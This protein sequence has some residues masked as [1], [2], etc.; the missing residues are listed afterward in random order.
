MEAFTCMTMHLQH[1]LGMIAIY[2]VIL[3]VDKVE[4]YD[5]AVQ[6]VIVEF[7]RKTCRCILPKSEVEWWKRIFFYI[8]AYA[9]ES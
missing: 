5:E 9:E 4:E 1:A 2:R 7:M 3:H 6:N 8:Q